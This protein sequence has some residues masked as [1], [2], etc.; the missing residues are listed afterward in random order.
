MP[1]Y[2][3]VLFSYCYLLVFVLMYVMLCFCIRLWILL[4]SLFLLRLCLCA[5]FLYS[6]FYVSIYGFLCPFYLSFIQLFCFMYLFCITESPFSLPFFISSFCSY[7]VITSFL[8]CLSSLHLSRYCPPHTSFLRTDRLTVPFAM[9]LLDCDPSSSRRDA[10]SP[11]LRL[12][13]HEPSLLPR[14]SSSL[15]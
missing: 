8:P 10:P 13:L 4:A 14:D 11:A 9:K 1:I 15:L 12:Y 3:I 7:S 2:D 6:V 5:R